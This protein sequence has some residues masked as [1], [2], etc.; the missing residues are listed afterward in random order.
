[1]F[2]PP[3]KVVDRPRKQFFPRAAFPQQEH[4]RIRRR[5]ALH[6]LPG[7]L[8]GRVL[9]DDA[10]ESVPRRILLP[11]H[12]VFP[13]QVLLPR[14]A[15]HQDL[16]VVQVHRFLDEIE[17]AL[18]HRRDRFFHRP[19]GGHQDHGDVGVGFLHLAQNVQARSPWKF[20]IRQH[21][22]VTHVADLLDGCGG[23]SGLLYAPARAL[24]RL[25]QHPAKLGLVFH[26][27]ERFHAGSLA[28][29]SHQV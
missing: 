21:Q 27:E 28:R 15:F 13:Q 2:P 25:P 7:R 23:V 22:Q 5:H 3:R 12:Q 26:Q 8:D 11:E 18:F 6:L 29:T 20:Q 14:R 24:Q 9:P 10:R 1:M 19:V 17:R 16:Q 4:R